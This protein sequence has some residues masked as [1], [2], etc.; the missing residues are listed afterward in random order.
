MGFSSKNTFSIGSA[1]SFTVT[2]DID[3]LSRADGTT[4]LTAADLS[5]GLLLGMSNVSGNYVNNS[6]SKKGVPSVDEGFFVKLTNDRFSFNLN[7]DTTSNQQ[8]TV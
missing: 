4:S 8:F 5:N 1:S 2:W 3:K 6:G 7:N